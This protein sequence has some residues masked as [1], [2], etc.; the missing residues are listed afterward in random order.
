[1]SH[2]KGL[3]LP[4]KALEDLLAKP[5]ELKELRIQFLSLV[6]EHGIRCC[7]EATGVPCTIFDFNEDLPTAKMEKTSDE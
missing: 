5:L 2:P 1:M 4:T 3:Y 7:H 6:L